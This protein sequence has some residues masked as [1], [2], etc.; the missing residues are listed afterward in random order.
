MCKYTVQNNQQLCKNNAQP[1]ND[2]DAGRDYKR[3]ITAIDVS[4]NGGKAGASGDAKS[5][6]VP[7]MV[8]LPEPLTT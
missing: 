7:Y 3:D 6:A 4:N 5:V 8:I 2:N 1:S